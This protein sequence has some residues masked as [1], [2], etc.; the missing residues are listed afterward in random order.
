VYNK[1]SYNYN[2]FNRGKV[3]FNHKGE[4]VFYGDEPSDRIELTNICFKKGGKCTD[5][6]A[7]VDSEGG[8]IKL[9]IEDGN[10]VYLPLTK[11]KLNQ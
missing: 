10:R 11:C 3:I 1:G 4:Y 6:S 5:Y 7:D 9:E 8:N 2:V